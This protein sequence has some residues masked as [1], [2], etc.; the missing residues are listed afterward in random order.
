VSLRTNEQNARFHQLLTQHKIDDE[1]KAEIVKTHSGGRVESSAEMSTIEMSKAIKA[2]E[3]KSED[4]LKR[5]RAKALNVA[6][7]LGL[8][9]GEKPKIDYSKLN[10]WIAKHYHKAYFYEVTD[11][12]ELSKV[13]T[14]LENWLKT[15]N[16]KV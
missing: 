10:A 3:V 14:G 6:R 9:T 2:L 16:N 11:T 7:A 4:Q 8:I 13:I 5:M 12:A 15:L 1:A